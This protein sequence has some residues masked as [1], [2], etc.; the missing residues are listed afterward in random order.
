M[1]KFKRIYFEECEEHIYGAE[2][3]IHQMHHE[4]LDNKLIDIIFCSIHSIKSGAAAFGF[5][6]VVYFSHEFET[7]LDL[8]RQGQL[9]SNSDIR[10]VFL[11]SIDCL[12]DI[13]YVQRTQQNVSREYGDDILKEL[14]ALSART[15]DG[16]CI[17]KPSFS[18]CKDSNQHSQTLTHKSVHE[19]IYID[20]SK[21]KNEPVP[22]SPSSLRIDVERIDALLKGVNDMVISQSILEEKT[23]TFSDGLQKDIKDNIDYQGVQVRDLHAMMMSIRSQKI[24]TVFARMSHVI[25]ETSNLCGKEIRLSTFGEEIELDKTILENLIDPLTHMV[26]NS[27][28][29]GIEPPAQREA[30]GKQLYGHIRLGAHQEKEGTIT[31]EI[32]DDGAGIQRES[33]LSRAQSYGIISEDHTLKPHENDTLIF[34]SGLSTAECLSTIS[35]R[36]IGMEVVQRNITN[37]GGKITVA[38]EPGKGCKFTLSVPLTFPLHPFA[39]NNPNEN[40]E[41][42]QNLK[43]AQ[44]QAKAL[45][46]LSNNQDAEPNRKF[47]IWSRFVTIFKMKST[48]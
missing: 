8:V 9:Q 37:I 40:L 45:C 22:Y 28:D 24:K 19:D 48:A 42:A 14:Q 30:I 4:M 13:L 1:D 47:N 41:T 11:R 38:S 32:A 5:Q 2:Q 26:R 21:E 17:V 31:I 3:A 6:N 39:K 27:I 12:S 35:G 25:R 34:H 43:S 29:H 16:Q 18:G 44:D 7:V 36:G 20:N 23:R 33:A 46:E 15:D 10:D